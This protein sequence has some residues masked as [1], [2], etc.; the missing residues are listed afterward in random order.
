MYTL[1]IKCDADHRI[2]TNFIALTDTKREIEPLKR[3]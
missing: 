3:K 1:G 2:E